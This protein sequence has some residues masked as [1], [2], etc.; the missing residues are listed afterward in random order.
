MSR[1]L[2]LVGSLDQFPQA[3]ELVKNTKTDGKIVPYPHIQKTPLRPAKNWRRSDE[4]V[5]LAERGR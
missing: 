1:H 3:L 5:F 4:K 2:S